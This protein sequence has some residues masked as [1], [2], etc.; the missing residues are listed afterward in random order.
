VSPAAAQSQSPQAVVKAARVRPGAA[1]L[2]APRGCARP[3][4][5]VATVTGRRIAKVTFYLDAR[6]VKTLNKAN[7]GAGRYALKLTVRQL[8]LGT[9]RVSAKVQFAAS[10]QTKA[11]TL[12]ATVSRCRPAVITPKFTG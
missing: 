5:T 4:A 7:A 2:S 6:K 8:A 9:H 12:H 3:A 11:R 10:S 1:T